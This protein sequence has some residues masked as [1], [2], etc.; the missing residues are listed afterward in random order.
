[1]IAGWKTKLASAPLWILVLLSM[2][3]WTALA[4]TIPII[5]NK[6]GMKKYL[7]LIPLVIITLTLPYKFTG[8]A[9]PYLYDFIGNTG[10]VLTGVLEVITCLLLLFRSTRELGLLASTLI[11]IG[12]IFTHIYLGEFDLVFAQAIL[13]LITSLLGLYYSRPDFSFEFDLEDDI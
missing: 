1:V 3:S 9:L 4:I 10:V 12:A 2:I 13:T 8:N 11:M 7:Y 6:Y 5:M